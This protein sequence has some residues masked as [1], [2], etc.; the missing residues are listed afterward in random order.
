MDV[1]VVLAIAYCANCDITTEYDVAETEWQDIQQEETEQP[2]LYCANCGG[3]WQG[4]ELNEAQP[5][6]IGEWQYEQ[7]I[8]TDDNGYDNNIMYD[9]DANSSYYHYDNNLLYPYPIAVS[10]DKTFFLPMNNPIV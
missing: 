9:Y 4:A 5:D 7:D 1:M 2:Q 10:L 3:E 8:S 6:V